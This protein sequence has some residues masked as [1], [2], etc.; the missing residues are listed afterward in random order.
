MFWGRYCQLMTLQGR[1]WKSASQPRLASRY[2]AKLSWWVLELIGSFAKAVR[3]NVGANHARMASR[4]WWLKTTS[5]SASL[6]RAR[7]NAPTR[8]PHPVPAVA[9]RAGRGSREAHNGHP[10]FC[11]SSLFRRQV[12]PKH[13][14][15]AQSLFETTAQSPHPSARGG[16]PCTEGAR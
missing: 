10:G 7:D 12:R 6:G 5:A 16:P 2:L 1:L 3:L 9:N 8:A 4:C 11:F 14:G 13:V 15:A